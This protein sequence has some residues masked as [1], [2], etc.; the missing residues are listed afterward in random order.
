M[1]CGSPTLTLWT[2]RLV[3]NASERKRVHAGSTKN[4]KERPA[5]RSRTLVNGEDGAKRSFRER[6]SCELAQKRPICLQAE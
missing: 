6:S 3:L 2:S 1:G 4:M 5:R